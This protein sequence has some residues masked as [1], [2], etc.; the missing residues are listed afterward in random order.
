[1][2]CLDADWFMCF[3]NKFAAIHTFFFLVSFMFYYG[4]RFSST[5]PPP[6]TPPSSIGSSSPAA[7]VLSAVF[8]GSIDTLQHC[9]GW[10]CVREADRRFPQVGEDT[11]HQHDDASVSLPLYVRGGARRSPGDTFKNPPSSTAETTWLLITCHGHSIVQLNLRTCWA[12]LL[13]KKSP[14]KFLYS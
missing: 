13:Q 5:P 6:L 11:D 10:L 4:L 8:G 1:M 2:F 7:A 9:W 12:K 14:Y 3:W